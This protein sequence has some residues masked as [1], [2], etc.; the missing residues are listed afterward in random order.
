MQFLSSRQ[1]EVIHSLV[2]RILVKQTLSHL[3]IVLDTLPSILDRIK[4]KLKISR[5]Y[6]GEIA[7]SRES[8]NCNV[9]CLHP[10]KIESFAALCPVYLISESLFVSM[11]V[12][13]PGWLLNLESCSRYKTGYK[14]KNN[15]C[16]SQDRK[17]L[18]VWSLNKIKTWK[19]AFVQ[20]QVGL[21]STRWALNHVN[22]PNIASSNS[23]IKY[24]KLMKL[25]R[26][27]IF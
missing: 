20:Y 3:M 26:K 4:S 8:W 12:I 24:L 17:F 10:S 13:F 14:T 1:P 9:T 19:D 6:V 16:H 21:E 25:F 23:R 2:Y 22:L 7:F 15:A 27:F 11:L 5:I 18:S